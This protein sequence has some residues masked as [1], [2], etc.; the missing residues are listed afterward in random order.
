MVKATAYGFADRQ[1]E[2]PSRHT[3]NAEITVLLIPVYNI[4]RAYD[5]LNRTQ[6][7]FPALLSLETGIRVN[8]LFRFVCQD[9]YGGR[10]S[11]RVLREAWG[12]TPLLVNY[13]EG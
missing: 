9:P 8:I 11:R 6:E 4:H 10:L 12:E 1:R 5:W 7:Q 2:R 3:L 13:R